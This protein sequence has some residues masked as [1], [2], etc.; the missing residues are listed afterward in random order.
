[1]TSDMMK[2]N[3]KVMQQLEKGFKYPYQNK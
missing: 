2:Q 3:K 1:M